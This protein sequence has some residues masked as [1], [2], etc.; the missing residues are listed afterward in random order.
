MFSSHTEASPANMTSCYRQEFTPYRN[1][2][3]QFNDAFLDYVQTHNS[4][5]Y[6]GKPSSQFKYLVVKTSEA[7]FGFS[8]VVLGVL[9][10]AMIAYMSG[11]VLLVRTEA[12]VTWDAVFQ[13]THYNWMLSPSWTDERLEGLL[14]KQKHVGVVNK[15][16]QYM[17]KLL[18]EGDFSKWT[19]RLV[20][21]YTNCYA[22]HGIFQNPL[23][24]GKLDLFGF[25]PGGGLY[26]RLYDSMF[27]L[28]PYM[29]HLLDL[30]ATKIF[31]RGKHVIGLQI[32]TEFNSKW[33]RA[34]VSCAEAV[35]KQK[36]ITEPLIFYVASDD[37]NAINTLRKQHPRYEFLTAEGHVGRIAERDSLHSFTKLLLDQHLLGMTDTLITTDF[38]T[39]GDAPVLR[40]AR[41]E[42]YTV[43]LSGKCIQRD[44]ASFE[45]CW[46]NRRRPW[47]AIYN[48]MKGTLN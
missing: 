1:Q 3:L 21:V 14:G 23:Y 31:Q 37:S 13:P 35:V 18:S 45:T 32:R 40:T 26:K 6:G 11:R 12:N 33:P 20:T 16:C 9:S 5:M 42:T 34:W 4:A 29:K 24:Q 46:T 39:F 30:E 2:P 47:D 7:A 44:I 17:T 19:Q 36:N 15:Q 10:S 8:N 27:S 28:T 25:A 41:R 43:L 22:P 48:E 38:S